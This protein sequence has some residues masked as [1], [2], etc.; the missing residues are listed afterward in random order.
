MAQFIEGS[1]YILLTKKGSIEILGKFIEYE[2]F[3]NASDIIDVA[4]FE[5]NRVN[6]EHY[7]YV[8]LDI[9]N[10]FKNMAIYNLKDL[11]PLD[12]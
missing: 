11:T 1:E 6:S 9:V 2:V 8:K 3:P 10:T 4:V 5:N 7:P 12:I